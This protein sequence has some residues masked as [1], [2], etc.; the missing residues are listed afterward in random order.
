M[1]AYIRRDPEGE[2]WMLVV[3]NFTPVYREGYGVGVPEGGQYRVMINTDAGEYGGF[4]TQQPRLSALEE[5]L[6]GQTH[7]LLLN[8]P[9]NSALILMPERLTQVMPP[10][11]VLAPSSAEE[12][13]PAQETTA[14]AAPQAAPLATPKKVVLKK[15]RHRGKR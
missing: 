15:V 4:G 6:H 5:G 13:P 14:E 10:K 8:L 11:A 2:E 7:H 1:Y 9:P 3:L 12:T